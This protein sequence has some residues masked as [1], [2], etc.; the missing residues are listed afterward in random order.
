MEE[1]KYKKENDR[2][3]IIKYIILAA[4]TGTRI[5]ED[6][7]VNI[8]DYLPKLQYNIELKL[9]GNHM[10]KK[11]IGIQVNKREVA[12]IEKINVDLDFTFVD[13]VL[14]NGEEIIT[15]G[16]LYGYVKSE[17]DKDIEESLD[18]ED[19]GKYKYFPHEYAEFLIRLGKKFKL[20]TQQKIKAKKLYG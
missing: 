17:E 2:L 1:P 13:G 20:D 5:K 15:I 3:Q 8:S 18:K 14:Q 19:Y 9:K 7:L 12:Q 4:L 11:L 6:Q 10:E 16:E